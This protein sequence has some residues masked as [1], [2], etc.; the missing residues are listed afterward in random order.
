VDADAHGLCKL[1]LCQANKATESRDVFATLE[2]AL[3]QALSE[4]CRDGAC[5]VVVGEF[6]H[7]FGASSN[8]TP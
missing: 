7:S 6:R 1:L 4:A 8:D 2:L 3:D 5:E